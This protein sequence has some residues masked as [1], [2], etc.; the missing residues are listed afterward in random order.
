MEYD[1][2]FIFNRRNQIKF[3]QFCTSIDA[4]MFKSKL[5]S[6]SSVNP[7]QIIEE[8]LTFNEER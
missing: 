2:E 6:S 5:K 7:E 8:F 4:M 1:Y 3:F